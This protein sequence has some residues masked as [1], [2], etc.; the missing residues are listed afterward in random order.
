MY[1]DAWS[2]GKIAACIGGNGGEDGCQKVRDQWYFP[3]CG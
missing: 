1:D 2:L 3:G